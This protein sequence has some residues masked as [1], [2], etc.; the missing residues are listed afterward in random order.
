MYF[1]VISYPGLI[2]VCVRPISVELDDV[3]V[4]QPCEV[5]K[6]HL[7]FVFLC[8]KVLALRELYF[9][10][11]DL[12]TLFRVHSEIRTVNAWDITLFHLRT[13]D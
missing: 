2:I 7:Y 13:N 3:G 12:D 4:L 11:Y 6:H 8:L 1:I 5:I 9:V 10:P